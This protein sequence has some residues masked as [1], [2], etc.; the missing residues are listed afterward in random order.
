MLKSPMLL[1]TIMLFIEL[2][3]P[4]KSFWQEYNIHRDTGI[5]GSSIIYLPR[6][7]HEG[8]QCLYD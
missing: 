3:S 6:K 4:N 5:L 2:V 1:G 7:L 8:S